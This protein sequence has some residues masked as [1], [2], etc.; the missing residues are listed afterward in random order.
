MSSP[1]TLFDKVWQAHEIK[2][3]DTGQ[4]LLWVDRHFVHEGSFHGFAKLAERNLPLARPEQTLAIADHY[5]PTR[6]RTLDG[7]NE[8]VAAVI[9][10]LQDNAQKH[11]VELIGLE[12]H[13]QGIVHVVG[14]ELGFT[15]P[16]LLMVCGD[17]H[18]ATHGAFGAIAFGIGASE[19]AH[20]LA[21]QTIWQTKPKQLRISFNG[22]LPFG[23]TAK[24]MAL[25]WIAKYGADFARG[26][27]IEYAGNVIEELSLEARLTLCNLSIEGGGRMGLIAPDEKLIEF[28]ANCA[29]TP[30]GDLLEIAK[31]YWRRLKSDD[32]ATFDQEIEIDVSQIAPTITWGVS[33]EEALGVDAC[34]P[35]PA[36][37]KDS[38]KARQIADSLAY[39]G[40][41]AGQPLQE[42]AIDRIFI[43]SCTNARIDDLRAA[44][45]VFKQGPSKV[46]G[47]VSPGSNAVK[48]QAEAEGLDKIFKSAGLD[49]VESGCSMCVGMNGD[50]VA[51]GE[52]CASTSNRNFKGRQGP[53][54]RTHLMSP[55]MVSWAAIHGHI[56]DIRHLTNTGSH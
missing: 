8:K 13:D 44:A 35:D 6:A 42:I 4:S 55:A 28:L 16:G 9:R 41:S 50:I 51:P 52:R 47:I 37:E 7:M 49:W 43:G 31:E 11:D 1:Q 5:V 2:Q 21:T 45:E 10:T 3:D 34:T 53:G 30:K 24:D 20:V 12:S 15:Q 22:K 18:T 23:V 26:Y 19:V 25:H 56:A 29:R 40:L 36:K 46:P 33:P 17:S 32:D 14:P 54:S 39:M 27:A 38:A 48:R